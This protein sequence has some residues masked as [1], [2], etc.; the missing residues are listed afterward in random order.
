MSASPS[1]STALQRQGLQGAQGAQ[2]SKVK[3]E[4]DFADLFTGS[5]NIG[6]GD[7][8]GGSDMLLTQPAQAALSVAIAKNPKD[9]HEILGE[10]K[11]LGKVEGKVDASRDSLF[12]VAALPR[13][14][15]MRSALCN[16]IQDAT[17]FLRKHAIFLPDSMEPEPHATFF[18]PVQICTIFPASCTSLTQH[19][20]QGQRRCILVHGI[21]YHALLPP[22]H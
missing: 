17:V 1:H 8:V 15:L 21:H 2:Q 14:S 19:Y 6:N 12:L 13:F 7:D 20:H 10:G 4:N 9:P 5:M 3:E 22:G 18:K 11:F 16:F